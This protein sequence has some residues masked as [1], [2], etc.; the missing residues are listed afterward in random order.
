MIVRDWH[1]IIWI[2]S[3]L[4]SADSLPI[5]GKKNAGRHALKCALQTNW[6]FGNSLVMGNSHYFQLH[7]QLKAMR[8]VSHLL[9]PLGAA[10]QVKVGDLCV[11]VNV[12]AVT[13]RSTSGTSERDFP[14]LSIAVRIG[15]MKS[16]L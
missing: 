10:Q 15:G 6:C 4:Q 14:S 3:F 8:D 5:S 16:V 11:C 9:F 2:V 7:V 1:F 12:L 13:A